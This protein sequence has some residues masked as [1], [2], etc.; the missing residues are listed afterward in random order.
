MK[1]ALVVAV[2]CAFAVACGS[3]STPTPAPTPTPSLVSLTGSV[4]AT[5]GSRI[6]G[7]VIAIMDGTNA[8]RSTTTND[9]G[10]YRFDSLTPGNANL[11]ATK[12][13]YQETRA[14]V[15]INGTNTLNFTFPVRSCETNNTASVSFS[16]RSAATPQYIVWDGNRVATL[17][18]GQTSDPITVAASVAHTL[19]F[20][21]ANTGTGACSISYPIPSQC[22]T[23]LYWC[24]YP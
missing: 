19:Q 24:A 14:G 4:F 8:G 20:M 16:N 23:A 6:V 12:T 3:D 15:Y 7:A 1:Q 13:G 18:P 10:D 11:S 21:N 22:A 5:G 2:L 9:N 17:T